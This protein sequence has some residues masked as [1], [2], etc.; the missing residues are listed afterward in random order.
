MRTRCSL[1]HRF[2]LVGLL[3]VSWFTCHGITDARPDVV[4]IMSDDHRADALGYFGHPDLTTPNLDR[5]ARRGAVSATL[6]FAVRIGRP[7]ARP[8]A[9]SSIPGARARV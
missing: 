3:S 7:A 8:R 1:L 4:V 2:R 6:V 9:S 5:F